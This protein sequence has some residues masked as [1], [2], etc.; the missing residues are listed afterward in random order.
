VKCKKGSRKFE[1]FVL[2]GCFLHVWDVL[3]SIYNPSSLQSVCTPTQFFRVKF[4]NNGNGDPENLLS[5]FKKIVGLY[6]PDEVS[7]LMNSKLLLFYNRP[8]LYDKELK[9]TSSYAQKN[10]LKGFKHI[11]EAWEEFIKEKRMKCWSDYLNSAGLVIGNDIDFD[12]S[13][14]SVSSEDSD[15][16]SDSSEESILNRESFKDDDSSDSK[17]GEDS[18][19]S[20]D[21]SLSTNDSDSNSSCKLILVQQKLSKEYTLTTIDNA[22]R[23]S[24]M[25]SPTIGLFEGCVLNIIV[26]VVPND[27]R[28]LSKFVN[29]NNFT[30][31]STPFATYILIPDAFN[32][33]ILIFY[34]RFAVLLLPIRVFYL[35]VPF[36][37]NDDV[38]LYTR[39][40]IFVCAHCGESSREK[41]M[42]VNSELA[43]ISSLNFSSAWVR[44]DIQILNG[45]QV[46]YDITGCEHGPWRNFSEPF[47]SSKRS[48]CNY[49]FALMDVLV[50]SVGSNLTLSAKYEIDPSDD[51]F[52]GDLDCRYLSDP[53]FEDAASA[54]FLESASGVLYFCD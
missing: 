32:A 10:R 34:P 15:S 21:S 7:E 6:V 25:V 22:T 18:S 2:E 40:Y 27:E 3:K 42:A 16:N 37:P 36:V 46:G 48:I 14:D 49:W 13:K 31:S 35:L 50:R 9:A 47:G 53:Q 17:S 28:R 45:F 39:P 4:L 19:D 11:Q 51:R 41:E 29:N 44:N 30:Y 24:P 8:S 43:Y 5:N 26:A 23:I 38:N 1:L 33:N 12:D 52:T 54:W 20:E